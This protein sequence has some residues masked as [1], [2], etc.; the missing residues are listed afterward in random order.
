MTEPVKWGTG[1][2]RELQMFLDHDLRRALSQRQDLEGLWRS[3]LD[4]YRA[5]KRRGVA[6]YP[7]EGAHNLT[8][9]VTA[10]NVDPI[11][12]RWMSNIHA[13][14]NLWT[15][16]AL[17]P[18]WLEAVKPLQTYL[19]WLD[20]MMIK[21][22]DVNYRVFMETLKLG[23]G[24]YK[25]GWL[26]EKRSKWG[27]DDSNTRTRLI[28]TRSQPFVDQVHLADFLLPPES[29]NISPDAQA[30]APWVAERHRW[31]LAQLDSMAKGQE[32]VLPNFDAD[33]VARVRLYME[34]KLTDHQEKIQ[35]LDNL[36]STLALQQNREVEI[37][38]VG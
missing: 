12:A 31:R 5:P 8:I 37:W 20:K 21:M 17:K 3:W 28:E 19:T 13:T 15:L 29:R 9:P 25:T 7:F 6:S 32:P 35:E 2:K 1:R 30:G 14:E 26:H 24:I 38:E 36:T 34:T 22:W 27:Y 11:L 33:A 18:G 16:R 10:M 4:D 23:T